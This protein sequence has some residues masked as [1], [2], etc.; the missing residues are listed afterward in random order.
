MPFVP[1]IQNRPAFS[2]LGESMMHHQTIAVSVVAVVLIVVGLMLPQAWTVVATTEPAAV[3]PSAA[4][5]APKQATASSSQPYEDLQAVTQHFADELGRLKE[6]GKT[7]SPAKLAE[8]ADAEPSYPMTPT[9]EPTQK[10]DAETIYSRAKPG[11]VVLGGVYKCDKCK[12]WHVRCASAFVIRR[13]GLVV[14]NHH[15]VEAYK[16]TEGL[17]I[18]TDDGRVFPVKAVLAASRHN[19]LALLKVDAEN[20]RP[21]PLARDASVGAAV[22][23]LSHPS[24]PNGKSNCFYTFCE[25]VVCGKFMLHDE[26]QQPLRV[27]A[28]TCDYG[29]GSSGG[30]ILNEHGA[31]VAVACQ[32]IPLLQQ[33]QGKN[34]QM[35]WRFARPTCSIFDMLNSVKPKAAAVR[36]S[37]TFKLR[38]TDQIGVGYYRPVVVKLSEKPPIEPKTEPE[39]RSAKPLYGVLQLGDAKQNRI[40]VALDEPEGDEP[41]IYINGKGDGDLAGSGPG[42]WERSTPTTF[43]A[44]NIT[45]DVAYQT[46]KKIPSKFNFY[47]FKERNR[48]NLYYYRNSGREGEVVLDGKNYRVLVLDDNSDGRFDDLRNGALVIDLN[49]DGILEKTA[50][51]AEYFSLGQPFNVHGTVWEVVSMSPDGLSITLAPSKAD[52]AIKPYLTPG[53]PARSSPA[54]R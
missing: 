40:L 14:T 4:S 29:P 5:N 8:Q 11:V 45:I 22:Y 34:V 35:I 53:N 17:G 12:H 44:G 7:V 30:P 1:I 28:V 21:L 19:D 43:F 3:A 50:D 2:R 51:S 52:V 38:P 20:L 26:Q 48:D 33:E 49:Q 41:E 46:G 47:R 9:A 16:Q 18:M 15:A 54:R 37:V 23:C 42:R 24:M 6:N 13:D 31:V 10:L 36:G 25:G 32:A 27:L 39:Y